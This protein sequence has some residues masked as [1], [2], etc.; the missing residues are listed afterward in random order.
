MAGAS[1][2]E[3]DFV[4]REAHLR[5]REEEPAA[6]LCTLTV[7]DHTSASGVKRYMLGR[8]ADPDA[9]RRAARRREGPALVRDER[10]RRAV[11]RQAHPDELPA[12]R[13]RDRRR[14]ARRSSTWASA[15]PVTVEVVGS[16]PIFDPE[17]TRIRS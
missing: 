8:R 4:G 7:D 15:I 9:R 2:K 16:T 3:Q 6:V 10:R 5:Q 11:D 1:V 14:A 17:N 13:A 12:A